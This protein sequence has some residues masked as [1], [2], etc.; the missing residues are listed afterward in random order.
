[1]ANKIRLGDLLVRAGLIK[2]SDLR[3][4]LAQQK[5]H[6][7]RLGEHLVR[8]GLVTEEQ[9]AH[10]LAQQLGLVYNDLSRPPTAAV[11]SLLPEKVAARLQA[12]AVGYDPRT[13][14]LSVAVSDPLDE[15][16]VAEI[17]RLTGKNV[18]AQVTP[19]IVLRR[20]IEHAYFGVEIRDEG[21]SEFQLMDIHGR[22]KTV[23]VGSRAQA[24]SD[25]DE[26]P[27]LNTGDFE[28][29]LTGELEAVSGDD[30]G[31]GSE[32]APLAAMRAEQA[33]VRAAQSAPARAAQSIRTPPPVRPRP[34]PPVAHGA[35]GGAPDP[36]AGEEALRMI[37][38]LADLLIERGY[39]TRADLM[40]S[41]RE[42]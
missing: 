14:V 19:A 7:G 11:V 3:V 39:L 16:A 42:K 12:L 31:G 5:Q 24:G 30:E 36:H 23:K 32:H 17:A 33:P 29:V 26:L 1:M 27:V 38:A 22:G 40:K 13:Q 37:W 6:G 35:E 10:A 20:A 25:D 41:L 2:E 34:A 9:I 15:E 4:V 18:V 28:P 8:V 21:T